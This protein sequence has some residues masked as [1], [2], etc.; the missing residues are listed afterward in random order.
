MILLLFNAI[1]HPGFA[2]EVFAGLLGDEAELFELKI[3][4]LDLAL[5]DGKFLCE[6]GGRR[7]RLT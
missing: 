3:R 2:E 4:A 5:V 7:K 1:I 6:R